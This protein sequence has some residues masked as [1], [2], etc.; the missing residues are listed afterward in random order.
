MLADGHV[1]RLAAMNCAWDHET[2]LASVRRAVPHVP[3]GEDTVPAQVEL[4]GDNLLVT[5]RWPS[6]PHVFGIR[7]PLAEAPAGPST[8]EVCE[9]Q[10]EW[11]WEVSLVLDEELG[12]GLVRRGRRSVTSQGIVELDYRVDADEYVPS[13]SPGPPL[14][15]HHYRVSV[16]RDEPATGD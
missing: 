10:E 14:P 11:A 12:T 6:E 4:D 1:D 15:G 5:F 7:F 2:L 8:G 3:A 16:V 9:S 13:A